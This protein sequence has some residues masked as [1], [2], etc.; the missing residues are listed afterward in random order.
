MKH[1]RTALLLAALLLTGCPSAG[2]R[3]GHTATGA[4]ARALVAAGALLLDVRTR[5]E[6]ASEHLPGAV[7]IPVSELSS[8]LAEV[9]A[10][11][12]VV[13]YCHSGGRSARALSILQAAGRTRVH[14]LGAMHRWSE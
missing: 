10:D 13:V 14:D 6:F 7:D 12:E 4:E 3:A 9:P 1:A 8:R 5:E 2:Q 11:R